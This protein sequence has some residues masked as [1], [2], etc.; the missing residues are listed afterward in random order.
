MNTIVDEDEL[1]KFNAV[2]MTPILGT[3][4][5]RLQ[6][7]VNAANDYMLKLRVAESSAKMAWSEHAQQAKVTSDAIGL[8]REIH[9]K[10]N[11]SESLSTDLRYRLDIFLTKY[12][13]TLK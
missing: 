10:Y 2:D 3:P 4:S 12:N 6:L 11:H 1:A 7:A 5:E 13:T 9:D 8:L